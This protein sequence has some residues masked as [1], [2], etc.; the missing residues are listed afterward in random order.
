MHVSKS[1]QR[2]GNREPFY[3]DS[4]ARS[5]LWAD[6]K[7]ISP[8]DCLESSSAAK[9]A[10]NKTTIWAAHSQGRLFHKSHSLASLRSLAAAAPANPGSPTAFSSCS[11][12]AHPAF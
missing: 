1:H 2:G 10:K 11:A 4:S 9:L 3:A 12:R 5:N 7:M 8:P 6:S